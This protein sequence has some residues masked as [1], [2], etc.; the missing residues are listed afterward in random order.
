VAIVAPSLAILGGQAVQA[1]RLLEG[2]KD[3]PDV[4]ARLVPINP[5]PPGPLRHATR[6]KYARTLVTQAAYWPSLARVLARADVVHVFSASYL[7]FLLAPLPAF[8][9]ARALGRPVV[10][11]Y[12]SGEAPDHLARSAIARRVTRAS[13]R[14]VV[15]SPFLREVFRQHGVT[16]RVIPNTVDAARF[17][18]RARDRVA[19]RLLSTRNLEPLYNVA[20]TLRLFRRVQDHHPHATLAVVGRGTQERALR[21]QAAALGLR[22]V[23][24]TGPMA[25]DRIWRAYRDADIYVQTPDI[26]NMPSSIL[27]AFSSG[28]PVVSTDAGGV[29]AIV[30]NG[31][32]G[33]LGPRDD[34]AALAAHVLRLLATPALAARIARA[35]HRSCERYRW[36]MVRTEWLELYRELVAQP[37]PTA[38]RVRHA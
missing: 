30:E 36:P 21:E 35:A 1:H 27:E 12:R 14:V 32:N 8:L 23:R 24:F 34:D 25:A 15:P 2:W 22:N 26:D 7:S 6:V 33:L 19:P 9:V 11:N 16:A 38:A 20:C 5:V 3:D 18:F 4:E 31:V 28:N 29:P 10:L 17:A 37:A 13:D